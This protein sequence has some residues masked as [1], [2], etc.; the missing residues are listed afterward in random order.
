M[1]SQMQQKL[2][3]QAENR[4]VNLGLSAAPLLFVSAKQNVCGLRFVL[5]CC[6]IEA[7]Q[8]PSSVWAMSYVFKDLP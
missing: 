1:R 2:C 7:V 3:A 6:K 8:A 4:V 5:N